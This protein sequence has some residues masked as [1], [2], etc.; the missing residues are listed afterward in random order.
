MPTRYFARVTAIGAKKD[1]LNLHRAML[2]NCDW[3][4][5]EQPGETLE[6]LQEQL[7]VHS[8]EE[9]GTYCEF[10]YGT[11]APRTFGEAFDDTCRLEVRE[12]PCGLWTATFAYEAPTPF[13]CEDWLDLHRR[14][15]RILMM[16]QRASEDFALDKGLVFFTGGR[17]RECWDL[18][19]ETW[20]W[21]VDQYECG[22][23]PEEAVER[24][25]QLEEIL[26]DEDFDL[27]VAELL[28]SCADN[29]RA[30]GDGQD[31]TAESLRDALEQRDFESLAEQQLRV[32]E[33]ALW[34]TAHNARWLATL[35]AIRSEWAE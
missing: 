3:L 24:L 10:F 5:D 32:A 4:D 7:R 9:G 6:K 34:A 17:I 20:L 33:A 25:Q 35:E 27:S 11:V 16:A 8:Q 21:L 31:V 13:Q 18:M 23:P 2:V 29:L 28:D 15:G 14:S 12:E 30:I 19:A 22:Y 26:D 1:M